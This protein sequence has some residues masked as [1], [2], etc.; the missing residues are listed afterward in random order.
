MCEF[1]E[2][3]EKPGISYEQMSNYSLMYFH[4]DLGN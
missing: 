3:G 1:Q 2:Y 4:I